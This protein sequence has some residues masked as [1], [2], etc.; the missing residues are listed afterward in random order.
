MKDLGRPEQFLGMQIEYD[1][2]G[3]ISLG[4]ERYIEDL[5]SKFN[6]SNCNQTST[7][8]IAGLKL[9]KFPKTANGEEE[10]ISDKP[11][12]QLVG[13]LN[14]LAT[15]SRPDIATAT[16]QLCRFVSKPHHSHWKAAIEVLRYLSGTRKSVLRFK[17]SEEGGR[18]RGFCDSDWASDTTRKSTSGY[19]FKYGNSLISWSSKLQS[20][21]ALSSTEAEYITACSATREAVWLRQLLCELGHS[22]DGAPTA[23][24]EDNEGC[25]SLSENWR[26]ERR[27]K[28]IEIQYH[29][30]REQV[31]AKRVKLE[32]ISTA[33]QPADGFTKALPKPK[34][35]W[36]CEQWN[37]ESSQ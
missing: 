14:W 2:D 9:E 24:Y 18:L 21:V 25:I 20:S 19:C 31:E 26:A 22:Q 17:R 35:Q 34:F 12:A 27:T 36:C 30:V 29:Y 23:L 5:L 4:Q 32:R 15:S 28:H 11:Y 6:V 7:P 1:E 3:S 8:Y 37:I 10:V 16:N 33:K 13:S